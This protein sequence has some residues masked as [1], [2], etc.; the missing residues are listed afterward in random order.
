LKA[1]SHG[2]FSKNDQEEFQSQDHDEQQCGVIEDVA[3]PGIPKEMMHEPE[4]ERHA[5]QYD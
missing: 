4:R 2:L 5:E 3:G 1:M